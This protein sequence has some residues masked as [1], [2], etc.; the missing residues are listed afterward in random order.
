MYL[1]GPIAA[2]IHPITVHP[3]R[4]AS[5]VL[6]SELVLIASALATVRFVGSVCTVNE[7]VAEPHFQYALTGAT[8]EL[9][10]VR[11]RPTEITQG[12]INLIRCVPTI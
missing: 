1:I 12:A 2:V 6:T 7:P 8:R 5:F 9:I 11:T 4:D 3:L 10:L